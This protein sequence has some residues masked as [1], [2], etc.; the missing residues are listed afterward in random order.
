[1]FSDELLCNLQEE[2]KLE[3]KPSK[4]IKKF[5]E[6]SVDNVTKKGSEKQKQH[7]ENGKK[8]KK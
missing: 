7:N 6:R 4:I 1:M 8:E 2:Q 5:K 3:M